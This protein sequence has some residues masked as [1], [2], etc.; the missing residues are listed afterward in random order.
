ML[1]ECDILARGLPLRASE[2]GGGVIHF[3]DD[4]VVKL[5]NQVGRGPPCVGRSGLLGAATRRGGRGVVRST[6]WAVV[7]LG[8]EGA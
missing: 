5:R 6:A 1:N 7:V 4:P 8:V 2:S 3:R